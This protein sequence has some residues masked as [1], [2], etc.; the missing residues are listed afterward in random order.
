MLL[1]SVRKL[2]LAPGWQP[3]ILVLVIFAG[4]LT[5][6]LVLGASGHSA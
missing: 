2:R 1:H 6:A 4:L 3:A 5:V